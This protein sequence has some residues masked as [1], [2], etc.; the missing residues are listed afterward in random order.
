[1]G[2]GP[3]SGTATLANARGGLFLGHFVAMADL[4]FEPNWK[5]I[6]EGE[7]VDFFAEL[8]IR[9]DSNRKHLVLSAVH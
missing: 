5:H 2:P 6:H 4:G 3:V 1:M 7:E 9:D 8:I